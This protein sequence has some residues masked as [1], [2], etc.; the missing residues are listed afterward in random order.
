MQLHPHSPT[1]FGILET[2]V[3]PE[4]GSFG[5]EAAKSLLQ[6]QFS[7]DQVQRMHELAEKNNA[8]AL[9]DA[10]RGEME[11]YARVGNFLSLVQSKAR[12]SLKADAGS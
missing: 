4:N 12:R 1:E 9:S 3:A 2:V 6:L 7:N 5:P 11:S 10:E 8:G